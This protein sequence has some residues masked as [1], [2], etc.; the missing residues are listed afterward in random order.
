[1]A[2]VTGCAMIELAPIGLNGAMPTTGWVKMV[3]IPMGTVN[4]TIPPL[5]KVRIKVEDKAGVRW[6]LPGET[7]PPTF[8]ANTY[9]LSI[10]MANL[11]FKGEVTTNATEF[12]ASVDEVIYSLAIR[13]TSNAHEGKQMQLSI[14]VAAISA[15]IAENFTKAGFVQLTMEG[16]ATT[17]ADATGKAVSP[18]GF[19]YI[20]AVLPEG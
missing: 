2:A 7:D 20:D 13:F 17:P 19:K 15:G 8:K 12:K 10:D 3:D 16:D 5:Q 14:P 1:M 6:V 9:D 18:W 4:L 11:L